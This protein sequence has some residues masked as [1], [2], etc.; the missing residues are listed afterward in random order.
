MRNLVLAGWLLLPA[1]AWA[2]HAGPGQEHMKSD[3]ADVELASARRAAAA[4]DWA[5]VAEHLD[6]A[7]AELPKLETKELQ[8]KALRIRL[9]SAIAKVQGQ[10]LADGQKEL[11]GLVDEIDDSKEMDA[12]FAAA[13]KEGYANAQFYRTFLMRLEGAQREMWEPEIEIARQNF[14]HLAEDEIAPSEQELVNLESSI[15][16]ARMD[17]D[18]LQGLPLPNQ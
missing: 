14:R 4:E 15:Q 3:A 8:E 7:L 5:L 12:A 13:V 10:N 16:L 1:A 18:E 6:K 17:L 2:Y 9:S 11:I